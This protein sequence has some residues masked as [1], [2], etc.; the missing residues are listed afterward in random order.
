[1]GMTRLGLESLIVLLLIQTCSLSAGMPDH[2]CLLHRIPLQPEKVEVRKV[3]GCGSSYWEKYVLARARNFP[4]V[5][6][7]IYWRDPTSRFITWR[8]LNRCQK[9]KYPD[10][11]TVYTCT[12]CEAKRKA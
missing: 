5:K 1:M 7:P 6:D 8:F 3:I 12:R 9:A 2:V 4:N 11:Q 10:H